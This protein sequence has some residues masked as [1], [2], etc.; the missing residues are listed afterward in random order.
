[1]K[2]RLD[3]RIAAV[4]GGTRGIGRAVAEAFLGEG[5]EV[6]INGRSA[7]KGQ[8]AL[9]EMAAG[10]AAAFYEGSVTD[11]QVVEG[12]VDFTVERFGRL[13]VM[14]LNAGGVRDTAPV[15]ELTDEEWQFE[16]DLGITEIY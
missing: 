11:Q 9:Q 5:A 8:R 10:E 13:D 4:T 12:L 1:M 14:V 6:V 3:G 7:E 16:L 15:M 2:G